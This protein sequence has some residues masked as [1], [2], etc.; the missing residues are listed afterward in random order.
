MTQEQSNTNMELRFWQFRDD[1]EAIEARVCLTLSQDVDWMRLEKCQRSVKLSITLLG[2]HW[3]TSRHN[4]SDWI[5]SLLLWL[6]FR[7]TWEFVTTS[8]SVC[9]K[10]VRMLEFDDLIKN[11]RLKFSQEAA[12]IILW[13][14]L[15]VIHLFCQWRRSEKRQDGYSMCGWVIVVVLK[16]HWGSTFVFHRTQGTRDRGITQDHDRGANI[17]ADQIRGLGRNTAL[18]QWHPRHEDYCICHFRDGL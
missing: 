2:S 5:F 1:D 18:W 10:T 13:D 3:S 9:R 12:I 16:S 17:N 8:Y 11:L 15:G 6:C 14:N 4:K 7:F